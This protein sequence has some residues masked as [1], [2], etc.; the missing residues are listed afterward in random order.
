MIDLLDFRPMD[1]PARGA[2]LR[3]A[4]R[5]D[6]DLTAARPDATR[7]IREEHVADANGKGRQGFASMKAELQRQIAS[8]GGQTAHRKGTAHHWTAAEA[9]VAGRKGGRAASHRRRLAAAAS[10]KSIGSPP[11][12]ITASSTSGE[13][14][15]E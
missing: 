8:K 14:R 9:R 4:W 12:S 3:L 6:S 5:R 11:A 2:L 13:P 15:S 7:D 10:I 1:R